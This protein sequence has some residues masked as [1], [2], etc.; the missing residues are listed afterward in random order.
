MAI[1]MSSVFFA[2]YV[3]TYNNRHFNNTSTVMFGQYCKFVIMHF[4]F[5]LY[6]ICSA[7]YNNRQFKTDISD[8]KLKLHMSRRMQSSYIN[9]IF[10]ENIFP[11]Q[12]QSVNNTT[13]LQRCILY[14]TTPLQGCI[15]YNTT[16]YRGV[17]CIILPLYRGV[18][19]IIILYNTNPVQGCIL[20]N[21]TPLQGCIL[22][23][24]NSVQG[25]ILHK[26][27]PLQGWLQYNSTSLQG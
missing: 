8:V 11:K 25:C 23:N 22:Y 18:Y 24:T 12:G 3:T 27:T 14:N 13:I 21:T 2:K 1:Y 10:Y 17:Y 19:C 15:L 6:S 7:A 5:S 9:I 16:L 26:T 4:C 20:F